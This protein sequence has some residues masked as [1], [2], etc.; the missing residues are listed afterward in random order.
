MQRFVS[1]SV[2]KPH[3]HRP[4][5]GQAYRV[6]STNHQ[7]FPSLRTTSTTGQAHTFLEMRVHT[8][9]WVKSV[10]TVRFCGHVRGSSARM[11]FKEMDDRLHRKV[12]DLVGYRLFWQ[13]ALQLRRSW[14][15]RCVASAEW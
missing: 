2:Y 6:L 12:S 15:R 10:S 1:I 5:L 13:S 11:G 3:P 7:S 4:L 9:C 8:S 14:L